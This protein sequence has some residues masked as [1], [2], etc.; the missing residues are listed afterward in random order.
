MNSACL[1]TL[2]FALKRRSKCCNLLL[3]SLPQPGSCDTAADAALSAAVKRLKF[4]MTSADLAVLLVNTVHNGVRLAR[5]LRDELKAALE[6]VGCAFAQHPLWLHVSSAAPHR[7]VVGRLATIVG[8][9]HADFTTPRAY[10]YQSPSEFLSELHGWASW[11]AHPRRDSDLRDGRALARAAALF[12]SDDGE[13]RRSACDDTDSNSESDADA[14]VDPEAASAEAI[15]GL[16]LNARVQ[17]AYRTV[18][19]AIV[20]E[21]LLANQRLGHL[22]KGAEQRSWCLHGFFIRGV[23]CTPV[24]TCANEAVHQFLKQMIHQT[25]TSIDAIEVCDSV[26][27][28]AAVPAESLRVHLLSTVQTAGDPVLCAA[29]LQ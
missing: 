25:S 19:D 2:S 4:G 18:Q 20:V 29:L 9:L 1:F 11:Y 28:P 27:V 13:V 7:A 10:G 8:A 17:D 26:S 21:G 22:P 16:A 15:T 6:S 5:A 14:D 23:V 12:G 3:C 24:G